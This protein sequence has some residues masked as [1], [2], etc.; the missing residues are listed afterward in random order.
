MIKP[1]DS[2]RS[3]YEKEIKHPTS[4]KK[5]TNAKSLLL[6]VNLKNPA[7]L[8]FRLKFSKLFSIIFLNGALD[9]RIH[10]RVDFIRHVTIKISYQKFHNY[11]DFIGYDFK[12]PLKLDRYY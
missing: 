12:L 1:N 3:S 6:I 9:L 2:K 8:M 11:Y 4:N 10:N 5:L 7:L